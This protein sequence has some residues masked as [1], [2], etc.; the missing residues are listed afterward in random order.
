MIIRI[1]SLVR[2]RIGKEIDKI[3][4]VY[5]EKQ[6][7]LIGMISADEQEIQ[8]STLDVIKSSLDTLHTQR[9]RMLT[10]YNNCTG[11][12]LVSVIKFSGGFTL[13][14]IAY[15]QKILEFSNSLIVK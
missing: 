3:D 4:R 5:E 13:S 1:R 6:E 9:E 12:D 14:I 10:L 15:V 7:K 11:Y 2:S 8:K